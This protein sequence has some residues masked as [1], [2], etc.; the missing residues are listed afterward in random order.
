MVFV[1]MGLF[2]VFL[3]AVRFVGFDVASVALVGGVLLLLGERNPYAVGAYAIGF[4]LAMSY[5]ASLLPTH[6]PMLFF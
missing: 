4:S 5:A 2:A 3:L 6:P 1:L